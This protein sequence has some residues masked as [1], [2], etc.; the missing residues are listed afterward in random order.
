MQL[1]INHRS[2]TADLA[3]TAIRAIRAILGHFVKQG[4]REEAHYRPAA[5]APPVQA[6]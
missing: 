2:F 4:A 1:T 6:A 5:R 3:D